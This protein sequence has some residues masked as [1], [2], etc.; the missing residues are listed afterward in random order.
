MTSVIGRELT[1]SPLSHAA[2]PV[3]TSQLP[4]LIDELREHDTGELISLAVYAS[5]SQGIDRDGGVIVAPHCG[6]AYRGSVSS[7]GSLT[8]ID[9]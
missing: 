8:H 5:C 2:Q 4:T 3:R 1:L 7:D 9:V 6:D